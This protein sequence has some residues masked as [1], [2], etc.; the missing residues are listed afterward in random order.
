MPQAL[1]EQ[2][3]PVTVQ[4][5]LMLEVPPTVAVNCWVFPVTTCALLGETLTMI[6]CRIVTT[7]LL[8]FVAS[9]TEVAITFTCAGL[10]TVPGAV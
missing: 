6:A 3:L 5:T 9:M 7:A 10:G 2:P 1:P 4:V 8:D